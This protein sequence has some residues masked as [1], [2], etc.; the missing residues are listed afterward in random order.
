MSDNA[1]EKK[2]SQGRLDDA[3][4]F[5]CA[6]NAEFMRRKIV[7]ALENDQI[8][9]GLFVPEVAHTLR[10]LADLMDRDKA[11]RNGCEVYRSPGGTLAMV[12]AENVIAVCIPYQET[13]TLLQASFVPQES[14]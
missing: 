6:G 10:A 5:C 1:D 11:G 8:G 3:V 9:D 7:I 4:E 12:T 13:G 14:A 2:P